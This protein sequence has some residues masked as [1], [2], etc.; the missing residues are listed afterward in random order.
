M[1]RKKRARRA[2][3]F[4]PGKNDDRKTYAFVATFLSIIGFVIA[5]IVKR[6]DKY[7]MYY[8]KNSLIIFLVIVVLGTV[9]SLLYPIPIIGGIIYAAVLVFSIFLWAASWIY[10]LSGQIREIPI[11]SRWAVKINL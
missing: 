8:A 7:V 4:R 9:S 3:V 11:I 6:D 10:A 1:A 2:R 5:L